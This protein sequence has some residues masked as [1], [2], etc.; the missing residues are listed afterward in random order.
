MRILVSVLLKI[1]RLTSRF[2]YS[3]LI[4]F[5]TCA[6]AGFA[7][8]PMIQ[9]STNL[10]AGVG[11]I[12][13]VI[14]LSQEN[15]TIFGE[16]DS[17]IVVVEFPEPPGPDRLPFIK[18][19]GDALA[20][21]PGVRRV[22]YRFLDPEDEEQV[23]GLFKHFLLGMNEE[24]RSKI[25]RI[26]TPDGVQ[27]SVRRLKNRLFL[28][29]DTYVQER[30]L[31]DPLDLGKFV[32][33]AMRRRVGA[34]SF[35]DMYLLVASPDSTVYLIQVTPDF[36]STE[37]VKGKELVTLLEQV[38]PRKIE[39]LR[40]SLPGLRKKSDGVQWFLTGKTAF[41]Y[42]SDVIFDREAL[43]ITLFSFSMVL[44]LVIVVYRSLWAGLILMAPICAG[45]GPN[46][47]LIALAYKEVNPVVMGAAGVLFGLGTDFGVHLWGRFREEIDRG[48]DVPAAIETVY[49]ETGPPV[50]LG[51]LTC[52]LA[53][54]CMCLSTQP[55]MAQ[56]G[57][58]GATGLI[59]TLV[60]TLCLFPALATLVA[61]AKQDRI[62]R[63]HITFQTFSGLFK[64][65][66]VPILL[67]S[68]AMVA[69]GAVFASRLSYEKDLFKVFLAQDM[70]SMAVSNRISK[71]FHANFSQPTL[72][73][74]DVDSVEK[75]LSIQRLLDKR[76]E[77]FMESSGIVNS[78]DSISYL[79]S[80]RSVH[81]ENLTFLA[82]LES[83]WSTRER[84]FNEQIETNHF[85]HL[86][87]ERMQ[88]SFSTVK[89]IFHD[90]ATLGEAAI[91]SRKGELE[92][93]WYQA[94]VNGSYRFLTLVRYSHEVND[95]AELRKADRELSQAVDGL[96]VQVRLSGPR[97][98]MEALLSGL[99]SE[100][101]RLGLY[102]L[103]AVVIFF[104]VMFRH[105]LAVALSLIPMTGAFCITLGVMGALGVG[106]PFSIVG[107]A[108]LIFG[109]GMDNGIHVVMGSSQEEGGSVEQAMARVTR[110]II[111]TSCTNVMG[112]VA[113]ITSYHYSLQF[114]GWTMV[115][116]MAAGV[117]L[118]LTTLPALL[119]LLREKGSGLVS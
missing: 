112:F 10:M 68:A 61:R 88:K 89:Q 62:P 33:E 46:Y 24:E 70:E 54:A 111:F 7:A 119:L 64:R 98:A 94:H 1:S 11:H 44:A 113:M 6:A 37:L 86:A 31:S 63:I 20:E 12:S 76:L 30:L 32:S 21:L 73:S 59:L 2:P 43:K 15:N 84:T 58:V 55:A 99:V 117:G 48:L 74:F 71:K 19:L 106:V 52:M 66:P 16:Q 105:P 115:V 51:G 22:R 38:I 81:E 45:V 107:V 101:A 3:T 85:S 80:P 67:V 53:F 114:L 4:V 50:L 39:E 93:S 95:T 69:A 35:G 77:R 116:G 25:G 42:E 96:P 49:K 56:F 102:V 82:G 118:S 103:T 90:L 87:A 100:L 72:L 97:Q 8:M 28:A 36:P 27:D 26:L 57:S 78:F 9:L 14:A 110:P 18:G 34:I 83:G 47:G 65:A 108:P 5:L 29:S 23:T 75:G 17:L 60:S 91:D 41:H 92:R 13:P 104:F 79:V 40:S 109:L